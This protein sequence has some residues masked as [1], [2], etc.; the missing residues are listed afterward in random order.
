MAKIKR[1]DYLRVYPTLLTFP[2]GSTIT[3]RYHE[4]RALIKVPLLLEDMKTEAKRL[5][6]LGRR[7]KMQKMEI[8]ED[9]TDVA[10]DGDKYLN[11]F[12]KSR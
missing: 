4:P 6:W 8:K 3:I 11:I 9:V 10:F 5:A 7:K 12:K 2:D 1:T